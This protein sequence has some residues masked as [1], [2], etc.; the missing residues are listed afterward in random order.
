MNPLSASGRAKK[1]DG[2]SL[3]YDLFNNMIHHG[4]DTY[5][6]NAQNQR[7]RKTENGK[8]KYYINNGLQTLAEYDDNNILLD[9]YVYSIDGIVAKV[10]LSGKYVWFYKDHLGSTRALSESSFQRDYYPFGDDMN[11]VGDE[12]DFHFTGKEFD[13]HTKLYCFL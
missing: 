2:V 5:A 11:D 12:T 6:Y 3:K 9:N 8:T 13:F 4:S 10:D 7:I 1:I